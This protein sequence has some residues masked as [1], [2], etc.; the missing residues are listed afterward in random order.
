[1]PILS[2][3]W[4]LLWYY[5][6][7]SKAVERMVDRIGNDKKPD[8]MEKVLLPFRNGEYQGALVMAEMLKEN[9]EVTT[10]YNFF[11]G[12]VL[13]YL[14]QFE[15]AETLLRRSTT[16]YMK[17]EERLLLGGLMMLAEL[18]VRTGR[19]TESIDV[20][21]RAMVSMPETGLPYRAKAQALLLQG[22]RSEDALR[23]ATQAVAREKTNTTVPDWLRK[24]GMGEWMAT[25][26]WAAAVQSKNRSEVEQLAGNAVTFVGKKTVSSTAL[27]HCHLGRAFAEFGDTAQSIVHFKEAT[28][29]DPQG[30]WG[31]DA[32]AAMSQP[33]IV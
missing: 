33:A 15:E 25:L 32:L 4:R 10:A 2:L 6:K 3:M 17:G 7:N 20:L 21:E 18:L 19:F 22:I 1:M 28:R 26:A 31:R 27:V 8:P 24:M 29:I 11:R 30:I 16:T 14:G 12:T 9:G 13:A 23:L 5:L